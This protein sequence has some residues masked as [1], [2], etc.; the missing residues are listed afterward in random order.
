[1]SVRLSVSL[2]AP[3]ISLAQ[4]LTAQ[5]P[6]VLR[7]GEPGR[8]SQWWGLNV[9]WQ[10]Q[11][12]AVYLLYFVRYRAKQTLQ[13]ATVS[14]PPVFLFSPS[15]RNMLRLNTRHPGAD[16][17]TAPLELEPRLHPRAARG[18]ARSAGGADAISHRGP[19]QLRR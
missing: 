3:Q 12:V 18:A 9:K 16:S 15:T 5:P 14:R 7:R 4:E 2:S 19:Q 11:R 17:L 13:A 8:P 1:M 6:H 10:Q